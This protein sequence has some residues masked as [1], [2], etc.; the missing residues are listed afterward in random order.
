[1]NL[2]LWMSQCSAG[3]SAPAGCLARLPRPRLARLCQYLKVPGKIPFN[4]NSAKH[5]RISFISPPYLFILSLSP[6]SPRSSEKKRL[7]SRGGQKRMNKDAAFQGRMGD[8]QVENVAK[9]ER[10]IE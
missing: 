1:M 10:G 9:V 2:F 7:N 6:P 4:A 8:F 3:P 5:S